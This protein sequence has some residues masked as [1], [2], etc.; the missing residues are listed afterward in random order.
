MMKAYFIAGLAADKNVFRNI[1]IP[2][3]L[4]PVYLEWLPPHKKE[5]LA[6]YAGRLS[7]N[8]DASQP[9]VLI[10]LSFGGMLATEIS[11]TKKPAALILI[12]SIP[13]P[14]HLPALYQWAGKC[15][16]QKILPAGLFK[17]ASLIKRFFTSESKEDKIM[18]R[19]MIRKSDPLFIKWALDA[20]LCWNNETLPEKYVHIHGGSDELLPVRYTK[21]T[22]LIPRAGHL[23]V[24]NRAKEINTILGDVLQNLRNF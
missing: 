2:A 14:R 5:T 20:I 10:G 12:S 19:E 1:Q 7:E 16:L 23:M 6:Q 11:R 17:K 18:L 3:F 22:H 15:R 8:I 9:F 21:P 13:T 4:E 24:V